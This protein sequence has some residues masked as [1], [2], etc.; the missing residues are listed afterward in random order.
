MIIQ[1]FI[2]KPSIHTFKGV[3]LMAFLC[4]Y[5]AIVP[6]EVLMEKNPVQHPIKQPTQ[7]TSIVHPPAPTKKKGSRVTGWLK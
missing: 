4:R 5:N 7:A 6:K 3:G 1:E 2:E